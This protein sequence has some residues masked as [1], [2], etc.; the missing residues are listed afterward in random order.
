MQIEATA[1]RSPAPLMPS[2]VCTYDAS[3]VC[4]MQLR[5]QYSGQTDKL[6]SFGWGTIVGWSRRQTIS[7]IDD[8]DR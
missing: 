8:L 2:S 4:N 5:L 1:A 7:L 6:D 3:T